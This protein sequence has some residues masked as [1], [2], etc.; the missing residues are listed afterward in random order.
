MTRSSYRSIP[1]IILMR[2]FGLI[3]FLILLY[4]ANHLA[5][6]TEN[7]LNEQI[8]QFLNSTIWLIIV[9]SIIFLFGELFN[10]LDF[11]FNLPAPLFNASASVLLVSFLYRT[12][13]LIDILIDEQI[14]LIFNRIEFLVYP[15]VFIIVLIGGYSAILMKLSRTDESRSIHDKEQKER[16]GKMLTWEDVGDEF[17]QTLFDLLTLVRRSIH[18]TK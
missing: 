4:I 13:A 9:M 5:F 6:F 3:I 18:K 14:F 11:P 7:P 15:L 10:A 1:W 17:K 2:L 16:T 8:I 12:F